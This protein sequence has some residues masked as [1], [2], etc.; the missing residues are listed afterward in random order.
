MTEYSVTVPY[1][2]CQHWQENCVR[3]CYPGNNLC[4]SSCREDH[5]CGATDPTRV[6]VTTTA[7]TTRASKTATSTNA[8]EEEEQEE[9]P[10]PTAFKG[11]GE[12]DDKPAA[13]SAEEEDA[14]AETQAPANNAAG[15]LEF[16]RA[17]GLP[18]VAAGLFA[19]F[20]LVM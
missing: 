14:P 20:G 3:G 13:T 12:G 16:G 1:H 6:N 4:Q 11:F 8:D 7:T 9:G 10:E 19:V 15:A 17:Y 2:I 5:P 18:V